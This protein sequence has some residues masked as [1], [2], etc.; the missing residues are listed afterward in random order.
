M[1]QDILD[2]K[3]AM[4]RNGVDPE[5]GLGD[6]LFCFVSTLMPVTN[7][8]LIIINERRQILLSWRDDKDYGQ[9]WHIPGGCIR[10]RETFKDRI[11]K[12]AMHELGTSVAIES[13]YRDF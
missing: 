13:A 11:Q 1:Q 12:T 10:F 3:N 6:E 5:N 9:G 4:S 8:D 2:F 7:V